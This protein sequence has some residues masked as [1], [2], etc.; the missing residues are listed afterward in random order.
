MAPLTE[1]PDRVILALLIFGESR[2][3][4]VEG[5]IAVA[6]VVRNR[7]RLAVNTAPRWRDICLAPEQF[8]C[9]NAFD[10]N[11]G[12]IAKASI[13]L[14]T[15]Q[16]TPELAQ[17]LWIADGAISGAAKDNTHGATHYLTSWLLNTTPPR[18]AKGQPVLVSI[19]DHS[20]LRV[21]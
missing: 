20:F 19:G 5:Q 12:P 9:F 11:A 16:P 6:N 17:A 8:S 14:M 10:P 15:S 3:E 18:W 2:G 13:N 4:P 7:L 21:A 1:L